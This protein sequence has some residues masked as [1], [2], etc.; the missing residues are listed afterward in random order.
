MGNHDFDA[1]FDAHE[2]SGIKT[3]VFSFKTPASFDEFRAEKNKDNLPPPYTLPGD[4]FLE[5]EAI[6]QAASSSDIPP[7]LLD[8][9]QD[10]YEHGEIS[11]DDLD[12]HYAEVA[13]N[14]FDADAGFLEAAHTAVF[15]P[16]AKDLFVG[17]NGQSDQTGKKAKIK[18]AG[19]IEQAEQVGQG[20]DHIE[21]VE[22]D[23]FIDKN[24]LESK[25]IDWEAFVE[26]C[27]SHDFP[28][29]YIPYIRL[30]SGK[31][32]GDECMVRISSDTALHQLH[33]VQ[34][35]VKIF[36]I[37]FLGKAVK[38]H[39]TADAYE[40]RTLGEMMGAMHEHPQIKMLQKEFGAS[41]LRCSDLKPGYKIKGDSFEKHE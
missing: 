19:Q 23:E 39:Y 24:E 9:P 4:V 17:Q 18:K 34:K 2:E 33:I 29:E 25:A 35:E 12:S 13:E 31:I 15:P 28:K 41:L 7:S 22:S 1:S 27:I 16:E 36:L 37:D 10:E 8:S 3:E 11:L 32:C 14:L 6:S 40:R 21:N 20:L 30:S 26:Y 5:Q 38:I